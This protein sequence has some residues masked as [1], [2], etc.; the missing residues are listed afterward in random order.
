MVLVHTGPARGPA[1]GT[2]E[3]LK[4]YMKPQ[5]RLKTAADSEAR[6]VSFKLDRSCGELFFCVR[7][8]SLAETAV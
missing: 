5:L 7:V 3:F 6:K 2:T 1:R 4:L 8:R